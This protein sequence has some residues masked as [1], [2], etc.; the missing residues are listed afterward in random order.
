[1]G[2]L[3]LFARQVGR[4]QDGLNSLGLVAALMALANPNLLWDVGFQ[5]S[6]MATLGLVLYAT[7]LTEAFLRLAS[8]WFS[9]STAQRLAGPVSEYVLLTFAAQITTLPVIA[10]YFK[11]ISLVAF[12]VNP[13]I[14]PAQPPVMI[15]GGL[16]LLAGLVFQSLG[17]LLAY[18]AWPFVVFT[19]RVVAFFAPFP[20]AM[21]ELGQVALPLILLYYALLFA[22]TF[23]RPTLWARLSDL[24]PGRALLGLGLVTILVWRSLLA[25][26]DG[27]LHL[28]M[29]DVG[30]GDAFLIRTPYRPLSAGGWR[31]QHMRAIGRP[32][33]PPAVGSPPT[34]LAG[35]GR[36]LKRANCRPA[37]HSAALHPRSG[38][39]GRRPIGLRRRPRPASRPGPGRHP[40]PYRRGGSS[41][42]PGARRP[43]GSYV[44]HPRRAVLLLEWDSFR[45]LLPIGLDEDLSQSLLEEPGPMPVTTLL[46]SGSGA[47]DSDPPE[48]L[49]AWNPQLVL[50]SVGSGDRRAR[51]APQVM[52]ADDGYLLLR[53]DQNG[54]L[55]L[56]TDG[57]RMRVEVGKKE[58]M[59]GYSMDGH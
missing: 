16:A 7:P 5:L 51:P 18:L 58:F 30:S 4:Q 39:V 50:L 47:A 54:W 43:H 27:R 26:P 46:L 3:A 52:E 31:S 55:H 48:W 21:L 41:P 25:V 11:R 8:R 6:F 2:A 34:R 45:L 14:L 32:R 9:G 12:L 37:G 29:L 24:K 13:L 15:V 56:S 49:Q 28:T 57:E 38:A 33:S 17:Q 20:G 53:T 23:A 10:Y 35:G 42:G 1:M 22:W 19:V 36:H 44:N 40:H 59:V